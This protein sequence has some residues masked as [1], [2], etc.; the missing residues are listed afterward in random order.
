M[1]WSKGETFG[2]GRR[3]SEVKMER[4]SRDGLQVAWNM[5]LELGLEV[6]GYWT[7]FNSGILYMR[8]AFQWYIHFYLE[9][10]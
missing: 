7:H 5:R 2:F 9:L 1:I 8:M 3:E 10:I 4:P 6:R